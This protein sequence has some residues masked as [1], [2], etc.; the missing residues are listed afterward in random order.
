MADIRFQCPECRQKIAVD[1]NA[2][3]M[4]VDCPNCRSSLVIPRV[5]EEAAEITVRRR[6][7]SA[8]GHA[9]SAY[10]ELERKQKE[11]ASALQEAARWRADTEHSREELIKLREDLAATARERDGLRGTGDELN[12]L[13]IEED[14]FK[15]DLEKTREEL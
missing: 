7:V 14:R 6:L 15:T 9:D 13:K 5:S 3:G 12:R 4:Q 10:E 11:L 2:A 8:T 1:D